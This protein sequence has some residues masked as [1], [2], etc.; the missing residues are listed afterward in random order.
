MAMGFAEKAAH[1]ALASGLDVNEVLDTLLSS[2]ELDSLPTTR[3]VSDD[4]SE[5]TSSCGTGDQSPEANSKEP[6]EDLLGVCEVLPVAAEACLPLSPLGAVFQA[7]S[8]ASE[9]IV[10]LA[11]Q[12]SS[13][14]TAGD[15]PARQLARV[16]RSWPEDNSA[17]DQLS[18]Q[19]GTV[20]YIWTGTATEHGWIYV[21]RLNMG[22]LAGWVPANVLQPL[23]LSYQWRLVVKG[24]QSFSDLHL[25][26]EQ[27]DIILVD[28]DSIEQGADGGWI[29]A[30]CLDGTHAGWFPTCA[31]Q[32][33]PAKLQWMHAVSSQEAQHEA[34]TVVEEGDLLLV[35]P[36][37]RT[38]EGWAYAWAAD[39]HHGDST[40]HSAQAGWV[41]VNCLE[42]LQE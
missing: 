22:S 14:N 6:D 19:C 11:R 32:R 3:D 35:D 12:M 34:Q 36:E 24:C 40:K 25:A 38:K 7:V 8:D 10:P 42:W 18:V 37:T 28:A 39:R 16:L 21:E 9:E 4:A 20:V 17:A 27:G 2:S 29:Y 5:R 13:E 26:A 1:D 30:E 15:P 23:P 41:P 33:L 31:L